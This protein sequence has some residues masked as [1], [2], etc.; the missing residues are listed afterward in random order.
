MKQKDKQ[1]IAKMALSIAASTALGI[2]LLLWSPFIFLIIF[3]SLYLIL[4]I[5]PVKYS[6]IL[7]PIM[8]IAGGICVFIPGAIL[9]VLIAKKLPLFYQII[10]LI[11]YVIVFTTM[12]FLLF[13]YINYQMSHWKV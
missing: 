8:W 10:S 9:N 1:A 13:D 7:I 12:A 3:F 4:R 2:V 11:F 6:H 5:D